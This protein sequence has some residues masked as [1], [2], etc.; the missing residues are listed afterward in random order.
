MLRQPEQTVSWRFLSVRWVTPG[1]SKKEVH[2]GHAST[3]ESPSERRPDR[4]I[5][6]LSFFRDS[7]RCF[8][9][10]QWQP[11]LSPIEALPQGK[12]QPRWLPPMESS[13]SWQPFP[14]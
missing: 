8:F 13:C 14:E 10:T 6:F 12:K 7:S 9:T 4:P 3:L 2:P 5:T 11:V 1:G